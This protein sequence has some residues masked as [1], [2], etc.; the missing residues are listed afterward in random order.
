[1]KKLLIVLCALLSYDLFC[2][3][4]E[5][6]PKAEESRKNEVKKI[7]S[8]EA[9]DKKSAN[10]QDVIANYFQLALKDLGGENQK[11]ELK[12]T[13]FNLK[14]QANKDLWI[15]YNYEKEKFSRNF[16]IEAGL[17]LKDD[18]KVNA[19]TYGFGWSFNGRDRSINT[20][21]DTKSEVIFSHYEDD[22]VAAKAKYA[23]YLDRME[24]PKVSEKVKIITDIKDKYKVNESQI[25]I[26][27]LTDFPEDFR[28]FLSEQYKSYEEDFIKQN[29]S[30][31]EAIERRLYFFIGVNNSLSDGSEILDNYK[32]NAVFL[33]GIKSRNVKLEIDFRNHYKVSDS[34][35]TLVYKRKEFAS[36][37]GLNIS[38]M[39]KNEIS[40]LEIKPNFEY[41][42]I[43][44]GLIID[45]KSNQF[46]ANA[47]VRVRILKNLWVPLILKY[48]V[49]N[50]KLFGFLNISFNFKTA[51][52]K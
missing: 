17:Y 51:K 21:A 6:I 24:D 39:A 34:T 25:K 2:Q 47:D 13:L 16:Q 10:W 4:S 23:Y 41:R 18:N 19:F 32:I 15:D 40:F 29:K 11:F 14:A 45:E 36:Q 42:K 33:K 30:D 12:T 37:L 31:I 9:D 35:A 38:V 50:G 27:P 8:E 20:L 28:P 49:D 26:I 44:S 46:F 43:F 1:M 22:I 3:K 48:D 7:A 52:D 5:I